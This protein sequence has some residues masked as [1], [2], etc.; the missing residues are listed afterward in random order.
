M[1]SPP[2]PILRATDEMDMPRDEIGVNRPLPAVKSPPWIMNLRTQYAA[3]KN[4]GQVH[5]V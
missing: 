5:D 1:D 2:L 3:I 4:L